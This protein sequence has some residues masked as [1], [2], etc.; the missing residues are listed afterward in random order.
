MLSRE[1]RP[2][3]GR[4]EWPM[5]SILWSGGKACQAAA[6]LASRC[7]TGLSFR[8]SMRC[9]GLRPGSHP[10]ALQPT[11]CEGCSRRAQVAGRD[12]GSQAEGVHCRYPRWLFAVEQ[13]AG[14]FR[15]QVPRNV[16]PQTLE[17]LDSI[18]NVV[19]GIRRQGKF[20]P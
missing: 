9:P 7:S 3:V 13:I 4:G 5:R 17:V 20:G 16:A 18:V 6:R 2:R 19:E 1:R 11:Y 15:L 12:R 10:L 14:Q 8:C